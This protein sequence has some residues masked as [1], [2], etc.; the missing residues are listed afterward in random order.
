M[1]DKEKAQVMKTR[2]AGMG[3]GKIAQELGLSQNTVKS[4]C[5][6]HTTDDAPV[7]A[8]ELIGATTACEHCG[9]PIQQIAKQK[10]KEFVYIR[11][12]LRDHCCMK[13][14]WDTALNN[15]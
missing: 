11:D 9:K 5:R 1:T 10:K 13:L 12:V 7:V 8:S 6:R 15:K 4:Y 3:D 14:L 2:V